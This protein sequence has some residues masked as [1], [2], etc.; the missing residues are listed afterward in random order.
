QQCGDS[1]VHHS[2]RRHR[3]Q[4][5]RM[6]LLPAEKRAHALE[7]Y[8]GTIPTPRQ[9]PFNRPRHLLPS[10]LPAFLRDDDVLRRRLG[11]H[12]D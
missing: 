1:P 11:L 3:A 12:V 7:T 4:H 2:G 9:R 5:V 10:D 8:Q 6:L